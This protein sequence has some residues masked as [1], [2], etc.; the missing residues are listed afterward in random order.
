MD[1]VSRLSVFIGKVEALR[2]PWNTFS[3]FQ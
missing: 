1:P 3:S 2:N